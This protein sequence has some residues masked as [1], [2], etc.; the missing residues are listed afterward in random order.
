MSSDGLGLEEVDGPHV[1]LMGRFMDLLLVILEKRHVV[2]FL[3][4]HLIQIMSMLFFINAIA[5]SCRA[6]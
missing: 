1:N 2:T 5:H 6:N 3:T 4:V